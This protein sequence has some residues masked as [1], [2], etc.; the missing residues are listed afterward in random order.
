MPQSLLGDRQDRHRNIDYHLETLCYSQETFTFDNQE[1]HIF[2]LILSYPL[3]KEFLDEDDLKRKIAKFHTHLLQPEQHILNFKVNKVFVGYSADYYLIGFSGKVSG[4]CL[5]IKATE[6]VTLLTTLLESFFLCV[7][8]GEF[9]PLLFALDGQ[10]IIQPTPQAQGLPREYDFTTGFENF[11]SWNLEYLVS[12]LIYLLGEI[13]V[14]SSAYALEEIVAVAAE[15]SG[16]SLGEIVAVAA[17]SS[18]E[19][20]E[21]AGEAVAEAS[22]EVVGVMA[23]ATG[24]MIETIATLLAESI[25]TVIAALLGG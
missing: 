15:S 8:S 2:D 10:V 13:V 12:D 25:V 1:D 9:N 11:V 5:E 19:L 17:E 24:A 14:E 16:E 7:A 20:L 18:G 22:F 3:S 6:L 21:V 4:E 23:E